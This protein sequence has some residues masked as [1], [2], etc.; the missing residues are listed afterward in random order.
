MTTQLICERPYP[1]RD[2]RGLVR[3]CSRQN[4]LLVQSGKRCISA[5]A[6]SAFLV[7]LIGL[8]QPIMRLGVVRFQLYGLLQ[9]ALSSQ[10]IVRIGIEH[11]ELDNGLEPYWDRWPRQASAVTRFRCSTP[12][13]DS[14]CAGATTRVRNRNAPRRLSDVLQLILQ[15]SSEFQPLSPVRHRPDLPGRST[16]AGSRDRL[17]SLSTGTGS[18]P[19]FAAPYPVQFQGPAK[20]S[21]HL[22]GN[23]C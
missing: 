19:A 9:L 1:Y 23:S 7:S 8:R 4:P 5:S 11:S 17:Q 14:F 13:W 12:S 15:D 20:A 21:L 10:E 18:L 3:C 16:A 22:D 6:S 2:S